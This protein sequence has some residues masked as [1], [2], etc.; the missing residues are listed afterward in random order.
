VS[1]ADEPV[2]FL[3]VAL[4]DGEVTES[5]LFA[6]VQVTEALVQRL[7]ELEPLCDRHNLLSVR[8]EHSESGSP[9][10]WEERAGSR[11]DGYLGT[12]VEWCVAGATA[13]ATLW[14]QLQMAD[15]GHGPV[16]PLA[17]ACVVELSQL[18]A[19]RAV[20]PEQRAA[21]LDFACH[22]GWS[23]ATGRDFELAVLGRVAQLGAEAR[24]LCELAQ[25][26]QVK[27]FRDQ[28]PP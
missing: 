19:M 18:E 7:R 28:E 14:G 16:E 1:A 13:E 11:M 15:G 27:R 2:I 5:P 25:V 4:P 21:A 26:D 9:V 12:Y 24:N 6:A 22:E 20:P 10:Y 3:S 8:F 23:E 17:R